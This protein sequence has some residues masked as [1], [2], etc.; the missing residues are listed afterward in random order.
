MF[1]QNYSEKVSGE[2]QVLG[3]RVLIKYEKVSN[4]LKSGIIIP[5]RQ[6]KETTTVGIV[7]SIGSK[8]S[9]EIKPGDKVFFSANAGTSIQA[10]DK[11]FAILF[12]KDVLCVIEN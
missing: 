4:I 7:V 5:S 3:E 10:N 1:I 11:D 6:E 9:E 8:V 12:E 2:V